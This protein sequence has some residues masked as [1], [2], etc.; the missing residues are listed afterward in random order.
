MTL[1]TLIG[2]IFLLLILSPNVHARNDYLQDGYYT[3]REGDLRI[4]GQY[5]DTTNPYGTVYPN[6]SSNNYN[7]YN[8]RYDRSISIEYTM[9]LGS[10]CT[11]EAKRTMRENQMLKQQIELMKVCRRYGGRDLPPQFAM[12]Q[13]KC[14][15]IN[16]DFDTRPTNDGKSLYDELID[17]YKEKNPDSLIN[18]EDSHYG[19]PKKFEFTGEEGI[20][21]DRHKTLLE[22]KKQMEVITVD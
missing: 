5:S 16:K 21:Q 12:L 18:N 10:N 11:P 8:D 3:C 1:K 22:L 17:D 19:N 14:A 6:S 9:F 7:Q 20:V 4:R 2:S 13:H 15:G